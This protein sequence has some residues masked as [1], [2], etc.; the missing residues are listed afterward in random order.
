MLSFWPL[1]DEQDIRSRGE[2]VTHVA[3]L[4]TVWRSAPEALRDLFVIGDWS[5]M[6]FAFC[7]RLRDDPSETAEIFFYDGGEPMLLAHSF[8]ELLQQYVQHGLAALFP[9]RDLTE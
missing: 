7:A 4:P 1:P 5:I 2:S 9:K 8:Q 3:P 6:C